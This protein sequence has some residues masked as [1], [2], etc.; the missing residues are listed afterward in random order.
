M[1]FFKSVQFCS[2]CKKLVS[3]TDDL[4]FVES[5]STTGFCSEPCIENFY[6]PLVDYF[7]EQEKA[8]R[9]QNELLDEEILEVVG[10]PSFMDMLLKKPHEI[11]VQDDVC[12]SPVYSFIRSFEDKKYGKFHLMCLCFTY[13]YGPSFIISASATKNAKLLENYRWGEQI[14]DL[15]PFYDQISTTE[16]PVESIEIDEHILMMLENKK[17]QYLAHLIEERSPADIPIEAFTLYEEYFEKTMMNPDEIY[18]H[19]DEEGD[20]I[21]TYIK[22]H[23]REGVSFYYF[24]ICS[25]VKEGADLNTEA[26]YPILSFPSV[27]GEMYKLYQKGELVSGNLRN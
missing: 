9:A 5:D 3:S 24:I 6:S 1:S 25:R 14:E 26:L 22:A 20:T 4:L 7:E 15:T 23:D 2:Q 12:G 11:W 16:A 19:Q 8:W 13:D 18:R 10:R 21:Y 27:D 17:S